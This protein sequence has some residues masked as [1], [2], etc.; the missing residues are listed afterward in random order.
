MSN[1]K[2]FRLAGTSSDLQ[3]G[4]AGGRLRYVAGVFKFVQ[5][6]GA[7]LNEMEGAV[8]TGSDSYVTKSQMEARGVLDDTAPLLGGDLDVNDQGIIS[9]S[10]GDI[11]I[12][13]DTTGNLVLDNL[14]W[15][16]AD[17]AA[18]YVLQTD[19]AGQLSWAINSASSLATMSDVTITAAATGDLIR[20]NGSAWA[21]YPDSNYASNAQ[22]TLADGALQE[23]SEDTVP[24]LGGNLDVG[25]NSIMSTSAGDIILIPDTTGNIILDGVKWPQADGAETYV[26]QTDGAGQLSWGLTLKP[27]TVKDATY[28]FVL[29]DN[30]RSYYHTSGSVHTWTIPPNSSVAFIIGAEITLVNNTGGGSVTIAR[31]SGVA[32]IEAGVGT[33]QD[34]TLAAN[35]LVRILKV[36]TDRWFVSG[37]G[38]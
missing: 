13:P 21:D 30:G 36:D 23:V 2:N 1:V 17:G 18:N 16:Q 10:A 4:P 7:T 32:L 19:G 35:G 24:I 27:Q 20:Y 31:G 3:I 11:A 15:P 38:I 33:D 29:D 14:N 8:G 25:G 28:T 6:D 34:A 22:G 12:T 9:T 26:L 37:V 5:S